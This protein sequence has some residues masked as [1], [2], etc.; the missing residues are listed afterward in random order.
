M[1]GTIQ[2]GKPGKQKKNLRRLAE[3]VNVARTL[4]ERGEAVQLQS[5][6][7]SVEEVCGKILKLPDGERRKCRDPLISLIE[8]F[9]RLE[10]ALNTQKGEAGDALGRLSEGRRAATAYGGKAGPRR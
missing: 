10:Y 3:T 9:D 1:D 4:V 6:A 7:A 5:L 2:P 8:D